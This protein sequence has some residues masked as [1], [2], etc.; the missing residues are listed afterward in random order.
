MNIPY[1]YHDCPSLN[2]IILVNKIVGEIKITAA[3][4]TRL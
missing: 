1:K 2:T 3:K 4:E